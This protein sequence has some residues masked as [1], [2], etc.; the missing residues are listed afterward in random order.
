MSFWKMEWH[1]FCQVITSRGLTSEKGKIVL[2]TFG[3]VLNFRLFKDGCLPGSG[4]FVHILS[5]VFSQACGNV[6]CLV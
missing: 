5:T 2:V 4:G 1:E 3:S 6:Y